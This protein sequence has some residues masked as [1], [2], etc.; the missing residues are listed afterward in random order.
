MTSAALEKREVF[1]DE[2]RWAI[3]KIV[4]A[5]TSISQSARVSWD[6]RTKEQ[7]GLWGVRV[8]YETESE[9]FRGFKTRKV[10]YFPSSFSWVV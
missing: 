1:A 8:V 10:S 5:V 3:S 7:S 9:Y 6:S 2:K 4:F